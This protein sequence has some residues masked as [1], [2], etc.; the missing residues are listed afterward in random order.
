LK[1]Y[2]KNRLPLP[3]LPLLIFSAAMVLYVGVENTLGGWLPSYAVRSSSTLLASSIALYF[4]AAELGSRLLLAAL[5][6][7]LGEAALY[8]ASVTLLII[9]EVTLI[10]A[11]HLSTGQVIALTMLSGFAL[12]PVYPLILSFLLAR[13][14]SHP[15]L[16]PLFASASIGG[17]TLPWLTGIVSTQFHEL[18]AGFAVSAIGAVVLLALSGRIAEKVSKSDLKTLQSK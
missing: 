8:R 17:A 1:Q 9:I 11:K 2:A 16:G 13:T 18:R 12:A 5:T 4:W 6:N 3:I 7:W 15:R 10:A 14:G